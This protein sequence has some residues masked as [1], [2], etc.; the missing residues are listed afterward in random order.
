MTQCHSAYVQLTAPCTMS[1]SG[2]DFSSFLWQ[3]TTD[4]STEM[5]TRPTT[6]YTFKRCPNYYYDAACCL[7][8]L[9]EIMRAS[10]VTSALL[11][12]KT[13]FYWN[14]AQRFFCGHAPSNSWCILLH[15]IVWCLDINIPVLWSSSSSLSSP[16]S[17]HKFTYLLTYDNIEWHNSHY[18]RILVHM[19]P[20][21]KLN[22]KR[23]SKVFTC[24]HTCLTFYT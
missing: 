23:T 21:L 8:M 24:M 18:A 10:T 20:R 16:V 17:E 7:K 14:Y 4:H 19:P 13:Q 6:F 12:L 22:S 3:R 2:I 11:V 5:C 9:S 1:K 15:V